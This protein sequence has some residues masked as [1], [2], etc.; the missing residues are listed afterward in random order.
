MLVR[1]TLLT[2]FSILIKYF[3][4]ICVFQIDSVVNTIISIRRLT[5]VTNGIFNYRTSHWIGVYCSA[6]SAVLRRLVDQLMA[7]L[8]FLTVKRAFNH[9]LDAYTHLYRCLLQ[10]NDATKVDHLATHLHLLSPP[11]PG[12]RTQS[13]DLR[14]HCPSL[15]FRLSVQLLLFHLHPLPA[16]RLRL[17]LPSTALHL[18][19]LQ[20]QVCAAPLQRP[21]LRL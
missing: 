18:S 5:I 13:R 16:G 11:Q 10:H 21:R 2:I 4:L 20:R 7:P 8:L 1:P 17:F 6:L 15:E 12:P 14:P 3:Y 9:Q 19:S